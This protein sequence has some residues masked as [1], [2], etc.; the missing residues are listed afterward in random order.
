[1]GGL[2]A[3]EPQLCGF[4]AIFPKNSREVYHML[5][6]TYTDRVYKANKNAVAPAETTKVSLFVRKSEKGVDGLSDLR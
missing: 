1:M 2:D 5:E 6:M 3:G 4:P